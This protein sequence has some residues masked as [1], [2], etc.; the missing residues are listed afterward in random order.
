MW[1]EAVRPIGFILN[2]PGAD[3][4]L[5]N[6]GKLLSQTFVMP[7]TMIEEIS[8]PF[9]AAELGSN[10][11]EVADQLRKRVAFVNTDQRMQM[12]WHKEQKIQVPAAAFVINSRCIKKHARDCFLAQLVSSALLAANGDEIDSAEAPREVCCVIESFA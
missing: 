12:V 10:S 5:T 2:Q 8:L 11:F 6:V 3:W 1:D 7:Q 4:I 9:Y